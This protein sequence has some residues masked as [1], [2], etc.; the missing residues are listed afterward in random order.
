MVKVSKLYDSDGYGL[1]SIDKFNDV[2]PEFNTIYSS[3]L[4]KNQSFKLSASITNKSVL[5]KLYLLSFV[6]WIYIVH[7]I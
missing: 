5:M 3:E 2:E 1:E 6:Y 7:L 4:K